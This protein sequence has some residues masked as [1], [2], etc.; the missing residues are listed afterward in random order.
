MGYNIAK[1][2]GSTLIDTINAWF[3][4]RIKKLL[5]NKALE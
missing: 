5:M 1:P 4:V 3:V 2:D